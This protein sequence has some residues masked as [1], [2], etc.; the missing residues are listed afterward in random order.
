MA[1]NFQLSELAQFITIDS[2]NNVLLSA[3][4]INATSFTIGSSF[5]ANTS[6][7]TISGLPLS[8]NGYIGSA[9]QVLTSNSTGGLYWTTGGNGYTGSVGYTGSQSVGY[10]GSAGT[11]GGGSGSWT[12]GAMANTA[13]FT[14]TTSSGNATSGAVT[15]TGGLGVANNV[16]VAGRVGYS[17][18]TNISVIYT[19]YNQT[20]NSMDTVFG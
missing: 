14:N 8:A 1:Q 18:S 16:Y 5:V 3:N 12:G 20:L 17:N 4:S 9:G 7:I 13:Q 15:I 2:G 6:R 19:Y 10:T 11:G